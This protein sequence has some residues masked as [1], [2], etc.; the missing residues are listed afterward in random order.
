MLTTTKFWLWLTSRVPL[1]PAWKVLEHFGT[2]DKAYFAEKTEYDAVPDLTAEE[3]LA[4]SDKSVEKADEILEDCQ[5][6]NVRILTWQDS[7]YP[8]RLRSIELPPMVLY[9]KGRPIRFD[10]EAMIAMAGTRH[11]SPYGMRMA[12]TFARELTEGGALVVT[13]V[14]KGCDQNAVMGAFDARGNVVAVLPGGVDVPFQ[15]DDSGK[16]LYRD[17]AR[18]GTMV[19]EYPPGTPNHGEHFRQ[20]NRI[21]TG[22]CLALLCVEAG[23]RSGTLQVAAYAREQDRTTFVIP[24]RV[25][26]LSARGTNELICQGYALPVLSG[27][28]ILVHY[29]GMYPHLLR[30]TVPVSPSRTAKKPA[31]IATEPVETSAAEASTLPED[32]KKGVDSGKTVDYIDLD[33]FD[34][35]LTQDEK[36]IL[37][38]I[39]SNVVTTEELIAGTGLNAGSL[40]ASLTLLTIRGLVISED[41]GRFRCAVSFN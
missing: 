3:R 2:P 39:G 5:R 36:Q 32:S 29:T 37:R 22:L 26:D 6:L 34:D 12:R 4:L 19:S 16:L 9:L 7:D 33:T 28:D 31:E 21:L 30:H 40:M 13:G 35:T 25:D 23:Q 11:A 27:H 15:N 38:S 24:A 18:Y 17:L 1:M 14:A 41:G 10:E 8:E 20:R